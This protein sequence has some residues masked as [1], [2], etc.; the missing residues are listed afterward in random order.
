MQ[1][2]NI[3]TEIGEHAGI[4][5]RSETSRAGRQGNPTSN[6][7]PALTAAAPPP[8]SVWAQ[9]VAQYDLARITPTQFSEL[10]QKL[11]QAGALTTAEVRELLAI[12]GDLESAGIRPDEPV[13]LRDFYARQLRRL[14]RQLATSPEPTAQEQ[15]STVLRRLEWVEKLAAMRAYADLPALGKLA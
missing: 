10:V 2:S 6:S 11:Q 5:R 9:I 14:R 4:V 15:L 8:P 7:L 1:I 12:R 13:D 3:L